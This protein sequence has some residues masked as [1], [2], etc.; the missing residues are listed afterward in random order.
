MKTCE[1]YVINKI[2][3]LEKENLK[4]KEEIKEN[5]SLIVK[6]DKA[7]GELKKLLKNVEFHADGNNRWYSMYIFEGHDKELFDKMESEINQ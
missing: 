5:N 1:E 4:L 7:N 3:E 6:L 2:N